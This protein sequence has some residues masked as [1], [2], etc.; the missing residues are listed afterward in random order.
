MTGETRTHLTLCHNVGGAQ[1]Q[2]GSLPPP[3]GRVVVVNWWQAP[4]PV[5]AG[6][7]LLVAQALARALVSVACVSFLQGDAVDAL[8]GDEC[9]ILAADG[10]GARLKAG[11]KGVPAR[12]TLCTTRQPASV[13]RAFDDADFPWWGQGQV[14]LLSPIGT[15]PPQV[16][17]ETVLAL[18]GD[19]WVARAQALAAAGLLGVLRPGVDGA[20]AGFHALSPGFEQAVLDAIERE[21]R[22]AGVTCRRGG[23]ELLWTG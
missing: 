14:L 15:S 11:L 18:M 23:E 17:R 9:R 4:P 8:A 12:L 5:D 16:D 10:L 3:H 7:P 6:V 21:A 22:A 19:D 13:L 20:I 1:W 2:L